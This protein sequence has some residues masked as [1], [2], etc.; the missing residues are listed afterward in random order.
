MPYWLQRQLR[1]A[2]LNKDRRQIHIL[3]DCWYLYIKTHES[4]TKSNRQQAQERPNS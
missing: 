1:R 4:T 2:F 3:N